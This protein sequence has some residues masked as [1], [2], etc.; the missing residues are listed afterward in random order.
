MRGEKGWFALLLEMLPE[1]WEA[2]AKELGAMR[3]ARGENT[4]GIAAAATA[5]LYGREVVRGDGRAC[6]GVRP[7]R[8]K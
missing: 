1:G 5:V 2:K 7:R 8:H 4:R 6:E 3:R